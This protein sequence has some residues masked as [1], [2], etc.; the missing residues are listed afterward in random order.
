MLSRRRPNSD[1]SLKSLES[2]LRALPRQS[3][4][5]DLEARLL[6]AIRAEASHEV[7]RRAGGSRRRRIA[8]WGGAA[9]VLAAACSLAVLLWPG[10]GRN[11]TGPNVVANPAIRQSAHPLTR[12]QPGYSHD[13]TPRLEARLDLD[14]AAR[15]LFT[16]PVQEETPLMV[17]TALRPDS[18]DW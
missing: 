5:G 4:P 16:W 3:V 8:V 6:A 11:R 13:I 1:R 10:A 9:A 12:Q 18:V 14:E 15:P 2:R 7:P 17:S